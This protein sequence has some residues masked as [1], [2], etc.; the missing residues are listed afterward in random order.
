MEKQLT[1]DERIA[2]LEAIVNGDSLKRDMVRKAAQYPKDYIGYLKSAEITDSLKVGS[3]KEGGY[4]VPDEFE[5]KLVEKLESKGVMR[6]LS[7]VITTSRSLKIP[8]VSK[9]PT[10]D[11]VEEGGRINETDMEFYQVVI[12][13]HKNGYITLVTEELLEDA[14]FDIEQHIIDIAGDKIGELEEDAFINGNGVHKPTGVLVDAPV[15]EETSSLNMDAAL[16]LYFSVG[17]KYRKNA[18]WVMSEE[19]LRIL[20]KERTAMGRN[21]W[22]DD[23]TKD[24]PTKLN[25]RPVYVSDSM[26]GVKAGKCPIMFG[27]FSYYWIGDRGN[28]AIKRMGEMYADRGMVGFRVTHRVDGKLV[29]PEAIKTLKIAS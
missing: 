28:R 12:D 3:D 18:V 15:G 4:L 6:K 26:P 14:G 19:A 7:N 8:G 9:N 27:D 21:V 25:G 2:K 23:M 5:K 22:E 20:H 24:L 13:A 16:N 17:Q 1:I 10:A 11:W 29:L